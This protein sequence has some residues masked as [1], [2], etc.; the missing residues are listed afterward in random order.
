MWRFAA[1]SRNG[2]ALFRRQSSKSP[3]TLGLRLSALTRDFTVR[4]FRK[5]GESPFDFSGHRVLLHKISTSIQ[6]FE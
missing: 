2:P 6:F 4:F 5:G 3:S 1:H